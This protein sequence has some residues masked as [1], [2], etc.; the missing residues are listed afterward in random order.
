MRFFDT[1]WL[2]EAFGGTYSASSGF[3]LLCFD[4][5]NKYPWTSSGEATDGNA[6]FVERVLLN[7]VPVNRIFIKQTNIN[8]ITIEIDTGSGYVALSNFILTKSNDGTQYFYELGAIVSLLKIKISGSNT[9]PTNQDKSIQQILA[10]TELGV[11]KAIDDISPKKNRVQ[12]I[13]KLNT[14]KV[15]VINKGSYFSFDLRFKAHYNSSENGIIQTLINNDNAFWLWINDD[16]EDSMVMIQEPYRFGDIYKVAQQKD[17]NLS[18]TGNAFF[19]GID[20]VTNLVEV[21]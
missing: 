15:D 21:P 16:E 8:N 18:F 9:T 2:F 11:I 20:A 5:E 1:N 6:I 17:S 10:F 7:V 14:G 19:S 12:K 13:S 4:E 3:P